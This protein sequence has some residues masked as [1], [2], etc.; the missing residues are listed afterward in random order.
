V[1]DGIQ[2]AITGDGAALTTSTR[3]AG[4]TCVGIKMVDPRC[5]HPITKEL[6]FISTLPDEEEDIEVECY[7]GVQ[8]AD[9]CFP[10]AIVLAP[11]SRDLVSKGFKPFFD[12]FNELKANGL[13]AHGDEPAFKPFDVICPADLSFQQKVTGLGGACKNM[14]FFCTCCESNSH[15]NWNL[16]HKI[17]DPDEFCRYCIA[18]ESDSCCHRAVNDKAELKR[19]ENWLIDIL[20]N[21]C[22]KPT[23]NPSLNLK[24]CLPTTESNCFTGFEMKKNKREKKY[25]KVQLRDFIDDGTIH[26]T[27]HISDFVGNILHSVEV[28]WQPLVKYDPFAAEKS[29]SIDNIDYECG[30]DKSQDLKFKINCM[31]ELTKRGHEVNLDSPIEEMRSILR[32]ELELRYRA[33]SGIK[34]LCIVVMLLL[35]TMQCL[36]QRIHRVA[37]CTRINVK[38]R[39]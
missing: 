23:N 35:R 13:P 32:R 29:A 33:Y 27:R 4:Q 19:K 10:S 30:V 38:L 24:D 17:T 7:A 25:E 31:R 22:R 16:F 34:T 6:C 18:N 3:K 36:V 1:S 9:H 37:S 14:K 28:A 21:D 26:P 39:R 8:S 15:D 11:E 5:R 2:I 20:L 12:F